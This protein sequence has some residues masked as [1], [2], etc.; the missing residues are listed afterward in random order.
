MSAQS[1][2]LVF[3]LFYLFAWLPV[4]VAKYLSFGAKYLASNRG[5]E[6]GELSKWGARAQRAHN[7]L[8]DYAPVF[9]GSVLLAFYRDINPS[10]LSKIVWTYL[11]ARV[12][13]YAVYTGGLVLAR[14]AAW[15]I[16]MVANVYLIYLLL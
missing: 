9:I 4:S 14:A 1:G 12:I 7:N 3:L 6:P 15:T 2:F 5:H 16:S 13:H 8:K 11:I 10:L